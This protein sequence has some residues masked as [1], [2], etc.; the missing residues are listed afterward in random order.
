MAAT[1]QQSCLKLT[2]VSLAIDP[3]Q[4]YVHMKLYHGTM[5]NDSLFL[6][7]M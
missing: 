1:G 4:P 7:V 6:E 5:H 2:F 3:R